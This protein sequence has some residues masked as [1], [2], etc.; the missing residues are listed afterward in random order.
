M[1]DLRQ[2]EGGGGNEAKDS[3]ELIFDLDN[4]NDDDR[5]EK[6]YVQETKIKEKKSR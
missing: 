2:V 6:I 1:I 4:I 3:I 5:A